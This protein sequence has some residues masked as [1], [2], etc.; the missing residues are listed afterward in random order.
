[1]YMYIMQTLHYANIVILSLP[2][3]AANLAV[4]LTARP[5]VSACYTKYAVETN[6]SFQE[7]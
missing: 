3:D 1:M 5:P 7:T 6:R 2:G 4:C